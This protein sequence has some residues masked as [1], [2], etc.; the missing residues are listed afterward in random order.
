M[1]KSTGFPV[2]SIN[3]KWFIDTTRNL[4]KWWSEYRKSKMGVIGLVI[5][6]IMILAVLIG[7]MVLKPPILSYDTYFPP[8]R[9][10]LLG[11]SSAGQDLFSYI[12]YAGRMSLFL[13][14]VIAL[15]TSITGTIIGLIAGYFGGL[16]D[17]FL[18]RFADILIILPGLPLLIILAEILGPGIPTIIF[19]ISITGWTGMAREIRAL[20]LSLKQY[21]YIESTKALGASDIHVIFSHI[22]PN[23]MG[24]VFSHFVMSVISIILLE[25]GLSFLGFGDPMRPTWGQMLNAAQMNGAFLRGAWWWWFPPGLCITMLCCSMGFIAMTLNDHFVLR[26]RRGGRA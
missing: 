7:P 5:F 23:V 26:L 18:M 20:T 13:G 9:Q 2:N 22:L 24:I 25:T 16:I 10:H 6:I 14:I 19:V 12:F 15:I 8:S 17:E 4:F 1:Q 11:T 21:S 3:L